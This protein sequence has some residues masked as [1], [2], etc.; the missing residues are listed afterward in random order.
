MMQIVSWVE[1]G[2]LIVPSVTTFDL[3]HIA[4]AHDL[5]QS[6]KSVGKIV[7][8]TDTKIGVR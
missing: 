1:G 2:E 7:I 8:R 6:G 3:K 5:I 4:L